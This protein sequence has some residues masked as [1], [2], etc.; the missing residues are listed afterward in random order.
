MYYPNPYLPQKLSSSV[1]TSLYS[2]ASVYS[3]PNSNSLQT[4][5]N[6]SITPSPLLPLV[7]LLPVLLT[8]ISP[9][10]DQIPNDM[11]EFNHI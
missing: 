6:N 8:T 5:T 1:F 3:G 10:L 9:M 7:F 4:S 2:P 11:D